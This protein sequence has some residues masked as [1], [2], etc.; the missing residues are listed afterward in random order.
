MGRL[1]DA[2]GERSNLWRYSVCG[3][4]LLATMLNYMDRQTLSQLATTI[5]DRFHL[6]NTQ[7]GQLD[8]GFSL[9]FAA[10]ALTFG[11]I[12]DR[13]GVRWLYPLVLVGWS[14][15]G[16]ATGFADRIGALVPDWINPLVGFSTGDMEGR[17]AYVGFM[18]CRIVLGFFEAGHWPCALVTTQTILTRQ[19]RTFGN[20]ILQSGASVGTI[21]TPLIVVAVLTRPVAGAPP[22]DSWRLPFVLIGLIGLF[23]LVPW[24]TLT[25]DR[26]LVRQRDAASAATDPN[27]HWSTWQFARYFAVL[28]VVVVA[29]NATWQFFRVWLPLFLERQHH[30]DRIHD[31]FWIIALYYVAT[32]LGCIGVGAAVKWLASR[33]WEVQ[34]ARLATFAACTGL[35]LLSLIVA[36]MAGPVA[37]TSA[38]WMLIGMLLLI[39]AG[40]LGLFP[41]YYAFT[42]EITRAHQG[43]ITGILGTITW[44]GS[45]IMQTAIGHSID[46]ALAAGA[47][48]PYTPGLVMAGLA[49]LVALVAMLLF[50]PRMREKTAADTA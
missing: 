35:V 37:G 19:D 14:L 47:A 6:D 24:L 32:D 13:Y 36:A 4:L 29:I 44:V 21:L 34:R 7:Y 20:S 38:A 43:K 25:R 28:V 1:T 31:V 39:G 15:A 42:Q 5:Q 26:D 46:S 40:S 33:R 10:G 18:A 8:S 17:N 41:N 30:F 16:I 45:A 9:A 2:S 50:W 23:W 3:L 49:P 12:A 48:N 22:D 11:V 27:A